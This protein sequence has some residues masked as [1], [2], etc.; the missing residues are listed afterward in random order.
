MRLLDVKALKKKN[1]LLDLH[2]NTI[3]QCEEELILDAD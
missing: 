2:F 3:T 1:L